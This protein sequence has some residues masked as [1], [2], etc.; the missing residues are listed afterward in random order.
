MKS[1]S[2]RHAGLLCQRFQRR[3]PVAIAN[4]VIDRIW[5]LRQHSGQGADDT[6]LAFVLLGETEPSHRQ[7]VRL[8]AKL[9][10]QA[11]SPQTVD[12]DSYTTPAFYPPI[13]H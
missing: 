12:R 2:L 10:D 6:V 9:D 7:Q 1:D 13:K 8:H 11:A 5:K 3:P 4:N